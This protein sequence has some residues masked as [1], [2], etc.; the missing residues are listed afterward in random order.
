MIVQCESCETRFHVAD[1]RIP[2]K[3]AR[4]RCS[5]CHHRFH[6]TPSSA[7]P[8]APAAD[9]SARPAAD[10]SAPR[11]PGDDLDNPEFLFDDT[12]SPE[13]QQTLGS[14]TPA[15]TPPTTKMKAPTPASA[16]PKPKLAAKAKP[17]EKSEPDAPATPE[18]PPEPPKEER[19][20]ATGGQTAQQMLDA[21]APKLGESK[22]EFEGALLGNS[23]G[24]D[25][26]AKSFFLGEDPA[27]E[28]AK[29]KESTKPKD[30]TKPRVYTKP[31]KE[32][33]K[34]PRPM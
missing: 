33:P 2:E 22:G 19:Y 14:G 30:S 13:T 17:A 21:G 18:A 9:G 20:V 5:R 25:D 12:T 4:V 32:P 10:G 11:A 23:V 34:P 27:K 24:E 29:L 7:A 16:K 6:I 1:A 28:A 8:A 3:G 26:G 31:P 15:R